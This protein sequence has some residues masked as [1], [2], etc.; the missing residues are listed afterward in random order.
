MYFYLSIGTNIDPEANAAGIVKLL[1]KR[2][3]QI[4]LFPFVRTEP[5]DVALSDAFLNALAVVFAKESSEQV[6]AALNTIEAQM[7]RDRSDPLRSVKNRPADIDIITCSSE[8]DFTPFAS[9]PEGYIQL[10]FHQQRDAAVDLSA[11]GLASHKGP[12]TVYIDTL[13]GEIVVVDDE[14]DRFK[15]RVEASLEGQ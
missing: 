12:A 13:T 14:F 10:C 4:A 2:F 6:K 11:Y 15:H 8:L 7:G 9:A 1:C 3:D 5:E